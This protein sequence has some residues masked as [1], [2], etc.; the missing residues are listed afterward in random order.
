[1]AREKRPNRGSEELCRRF[2]EHGGKTEVSRAVGVGVDV[3]SRWMSGAT[4]PD[5][6][7]RVK[8][9]KLYKIPL[10]DWDEPPPPAESDVGATG[11]GPPSQEEEAG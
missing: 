3:V 1:M 10:L 8:L 9:K 5:V 2:P 6:E 4:R 11:D 7:W